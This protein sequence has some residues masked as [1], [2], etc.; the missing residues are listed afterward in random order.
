MK[1]ILIHV[2]LCM[3]V[4]ALAGCVVPSHEL[5]RPRA[6]PITD[7]PDIYEAL[8]DYYASPPDGGKPI[9]LVHV[10]LFRFSAR[11]KHFAAIVD[12]EKNWW[13]EFVVFEYDD[14]KI[15]WVATVDQ[16]PTEQSILAIKPATLPGFDGPMLEVFG[17]T[18]MGHGNFY[19]YHFDIDNR[20]LELKL[21]TFAVDNHQDGTLIR[22]GKL[23]PVYYAPGRLR[24]QGN[25]VFVG[26]IDYYPEDA[27]VDDPGEPIKA[28]R[29][30]KMFY[31]STGQGR[32]ITEPDDWQGLSDYEGHE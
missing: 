7:R 8:A 15:Q 6:Y 32:Y 20:K 4:L 16:M 9:E 5:P 24:H 1:R 23:T 3:C 25:I 13:G 10:E 29:A 19:L 21:K 14:D 26:I 17:Q 11:T 30:Y 18:H 12:W 2:V 22:G 31:Y 27:P 28:R